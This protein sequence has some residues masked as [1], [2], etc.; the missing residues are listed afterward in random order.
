VSPEEAARLKLLRTAPLN[1]WVALSCD[2]SKILATAATYSEVIELCEQAGEKD[3][4]IIKTPEQWSSLAVWVN[5]KI[6]YKAYPDVYGPPDSFI[7][8]VMLDVQVALPQLNAPRTRRFDAIVDSGASRTLLHADL[9]RHL[10][11]ELKAGEIE[12]AQGIGGSEEIYLHEITLFLPGGPV[13]TKA[14][15]KDRLPVAGLLGMKG[16]FEFFRVTFD[17]AQKICEIDRNY[18]A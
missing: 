4:L 11:L 5:L 15:F 8:A 7:Y 17:S 9:A 12:R 3:P 10:G 18:R 1:S 13:T 16:F 6:K 14:G 2:E